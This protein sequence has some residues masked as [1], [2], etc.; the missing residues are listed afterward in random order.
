MGEIWDR[1]RTRSALIRLALAAS[2][3]LWLFGPLELRSWIPVWLPFLVALGLELQFF[4]GARRGGGA[5]ERRGRE[6]Q[7]IDQERYGYVGEEL[8]LVRRDGEEL[9][10]PYA[11][12]SPEELDELLE[13]AERPALEGR[14]YAPEVRRAGPLRRFAVGLAVIAALAGGAWL[15]ESNRGWSGLD[16]GERAAAEELFSAEAQRI[17]RHDVEIR[18]DES[19][20]RVGAVQHA[21]GVATV[22]GDLAYLTPEICWDLYRLAFRDEPPTGA[23]GRA[24]AVLAHEA[25]HLHGIRD[26]ATTECYALQSGV[27]LGERLGLARSTAR[28]LMQQQLVENS[29]RTISSLEYRV[30]ADCRD[31]GPL[32]LNAARDEFP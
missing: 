11:G 1:L 31:G 23:T 14:P 19:G 22:G 16:G 29:R 18:C 27:D 13:G 21:D 8:V 2:V 20:E 32:D 24:V 7:A 26:E 12:E 9:W 10:L 15:I 17:A 25:W 3:L 5:P 30:T 28:R 4:L 6:P